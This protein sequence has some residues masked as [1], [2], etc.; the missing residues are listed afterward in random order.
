[1]WNLG[2]ADP[3]GA[4]LL[5]PVPRPHGAHRP[6]FVSHFLV[7]ETRTTDVTTVV[8]APGMPSIEDNPTARVGEPGSDHAAVVATFQF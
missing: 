2:A 4:S 8:A 7:T 1:M 5:A 6:R 3:G